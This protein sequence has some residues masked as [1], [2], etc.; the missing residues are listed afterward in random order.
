MKYSAVLI[1]ILLP[2]LVLAG[3]VTETRNLALPSEG[4]DTLV[5]RCGAGSLR[6]SGAPA[7][8]KIRVSAQNEGENFSETDFKAYLQ[9]NLTL[10][11]LRQANRAILLS[12]FKGPPR[13]DQ[14][15]RINLEIEIPDNI[16]L[17][18]VDGSG[19]ISI[20]DLKADI[21]IDD[22][23]GSITMK[24]VSGE[25]R[26]EDSSGSIAIEETTGDIIIITGDIFYDSDSP[27]KS[28][29]LGKQG[30]LVRVVPFLID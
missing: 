3:T 21:R 1:F 28:E 14:D 19:S 4:I 2:G 23:T 16:N 12:D 5:I 27:D 26:I 15:A 8:G 24:N 25:V 20:Q 22:D 17:D 13:P 9:K 7:G 10:S 30:R 11:L 6:L 18:I 29:S